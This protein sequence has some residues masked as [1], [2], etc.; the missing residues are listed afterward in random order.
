MSP[1]PRTM[2]ATLRLAREDENCGLDAFHLRFRVDSEVGLPDARCYTADCGARGKCQSIPSLVCLR[3]MFVPLP[4]KLGDRTDD[5]P[6]TDTSSALRSS[7][8]LWWCLRLCSA[9]Q[10]RMS[11]SV[12][13]RAIGA[14]SA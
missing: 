5:R 4:P 10:D 6:P 9:R 13:R 3:H 1:D 7:R 14:M 12:A 2:L 11:C 8:L